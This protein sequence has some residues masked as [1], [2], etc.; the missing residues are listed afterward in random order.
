M[1][2]MGQYCIPPGNSFIL[3]AFWGAVDLPNP[4]KR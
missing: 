1:A 3:F 2:E 4:D